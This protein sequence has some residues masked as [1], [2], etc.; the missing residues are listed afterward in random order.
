MSE[1][2]TFARPE[3]RVPVGV[4]DRVGLGTTTWTLLRWTMAQTGAMLPLFV[5]VQ[6]AIAGPSS[7][8]S[9]FSS[10]ISTRPR[11]SCCPPVPPPSSS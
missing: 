10:P 2:T 5:V 1:P 8:G 3:A 7:S 9:A 11:R 6:A 4:P